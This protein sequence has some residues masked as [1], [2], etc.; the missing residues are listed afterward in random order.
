MI[1]TQISLQTPE[2]SQNSSNIVRGKKPKKSILKT[3]SSCMVQNTQKSTPLTLE[4]TGVKDNLQAQ[5]QENEVS[6]GKE[7]R[8]LNS[9]NSVAMKGA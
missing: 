9:I 1:P 5:K 2:G 7:A 8:L 4:K 6:I 3:P